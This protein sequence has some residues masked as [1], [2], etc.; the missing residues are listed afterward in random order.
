MK[1]QNQNKHSDVMEFQSKRSGG[2]ETKGMRY[3]NI[4]NDLN[5]NPN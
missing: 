5:G 3:K 4:L 2:A 1:N